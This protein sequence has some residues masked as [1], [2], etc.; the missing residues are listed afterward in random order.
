[1]RLILDVS[2]LRLRG[3]A[4]HA[5]DRPS[6]RTEVSTHILPSVMDRRYYK[7]QTRA[8]D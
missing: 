6:T 7:D 1:M 5:A 2:L 3:R 4:C 8:I